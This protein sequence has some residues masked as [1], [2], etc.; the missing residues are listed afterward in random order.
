MSAG[1]VI[2][3]HGLQSN[4]E[5]TKAT[6]LAAV[7]DQLGWTH[8]RPD[9]C[10]LDAVG[11]LGDVLGR[12]DRLQRRAA[13]QTGRLVLAGSSMGAFICARVSLAVPV[14][15]LFLM[16]PPTSLMG[17]EI[18]L[19]AAPVPTRIVHGWHDEL[20]P[21]AEVVRWA[22]S[23]A[24]RL[25]LVDDGHRLARHV[26]LCADEFSRFLRELA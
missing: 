8:E 20:I 26:D 10:D 23:R 21:A 13:V 3:C 2:I 18:A 15:G 14:A 4:P 25:T 5:A 11:Q 12:I 6:A 19:E 9:F 16:A 17:F 7:A 22:Q 24:D 1:H